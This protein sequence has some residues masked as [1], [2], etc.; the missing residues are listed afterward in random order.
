MRRPFRRPGKR[1]PRWVSLAVALVLATTGLTGLTGVPGSSGAAATAGAPAQPARAAAPAPGAQPARAAAHTVGF[2]HYSLTIDGHRLYLWSAEF[3]YWRLPSP[4]LWR[5][6]LEKLKAAGYN[7]T[8][9]YFDWGYH[10][11]A[12]GVYDFTGV[13][14]ID[15]L[16]DI[17]EEV[18]IY[19]IARPGPYINAETD[20]GGFPGWLVTQRGRARSS[21]PDFTAA[22]RDWLRRVDRIIARHQI[23]DGGGPVILYQIEN[24]YGNNTDAQYMQDQQAQVRADGITVPLTHNHCCGPSTWAT[25]PGSVDI[26]G[27]DSYPQGF[28]CSTPDRWNGVSTLP[29]FRDDAPIFTPEFQGGSFDPWGGPGYD[30]CRTLTGPDFE[31]VFYKNNIAAGATLQNFYMTYGGTSW[32]WLADPAQVYTSYDYGAAIKED[33]ELTAKYDETKRLGY[34]TQSF[35]PLTKT[36][37]IASQAPTSPAVRVDGRA[38]PD[39]NTHLYVVRHRDSTAT[40]TDRTHI[41]VDLSAK[42]VYTHDDPDGAL[43]YAGAGWSHVANESF[44]SGDYKNTESFSDQAGDSVTVTFTGTAVR[45]I[46]SYDA[47]HGIA[48]VFLDGTKVAT[49][50]GYGA[51][52][53]FQQV[54]YAASGLADGPHTLR[55]VAT[56]TANPAASGTFVV[57][58]AIDVPA[59]AGSGA[60]DVYP[61]VPQQPGTD[62]TLA[63]RDSKLIIAGYDMDSQRLQYSTS[64]LMTHGHIAGRDVALL[65]GRSGQDG[66][67]VLR[68]AAE[69][70][71]TVLSGSVQHTWDAARRDLRLNY[72]HGGLARVLVTPTGGAAGDDAAPLLL[73]IGTD[74]VAAQF[75]RQD[76]AAGP[77]LVRGPKLV[78]SASHAAGV[79][80]LRGDTTA[81]TDIEVYAAQTVRTITWN[82]ARVP[83]PRRG[84]DG[85]LTGRLAGPRP[86]TPPALTDWRFRQESP[87]ARPEFDDGRWRLA[88]KATTNNPTQPSAP[89]VLYADEYGFHHGD[90][91][92]RGHFTAHGEETGVS[93]SA[94]TGRA[95]TYSAWLNGTFL[96]STGDRAHRFDFP[97]GS[98]RPGRDN[99]LSVLVENMGHNEDFNADDSHKEPRGLTGATILGSTAQLGWRI[100]GSLGGE[101]L[102]DPARG[103]MNV[104]GLFG[105]RGGWHLPGFPDAA[106]SRVTLPRSDTRPGVAWYR[107]TF[108]LDLP[109]DQDVPMGV[110]IT[111]DPARRYRALLFVNGWQLGRYINHVGPQRTFPVPPGILRT[112]GANTLAIAVWNEDGDTGGLGAVTLDQYANL[113]T[114]LRVSNVP[115][116]PYDPRVYRT[117]ASTAALSVTG[118]DIIERGGTGTVTATFADPAG[119]PAARDVTVRLRAPDGWTVTPAGAVRLGTVRPGASTS[120]AW[121]VTGPAGDQPGAAVFSSTASYSQGG[122]GDAADGAAVVRVPPPPPTGSVFV[123]DIPFTSTNGWGPVERD[124]SNGE[125]AAGDGRTI[126]LNGTTYAKG[127]GVHAVGDVSVFLGGNCGRFTAVA[128]VDDEVGSSGSVTFSVVGDGATL[129]TTPTLTGSSTSAEIDVDVS[130]VQQ[131]DLVIGDGGNGNGTDHGDWA[132][133]RLSCAAP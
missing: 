132:D 74:E 88:D 112:N 111:D 1:L 110:R 79:L 73:L 43:A 15:R 87:E 38:N 44:T 99:V 62:I 18:G 24:E 126:T 76:T 101:D 115:S 3:H 20:S 120:A 65:Y 23:T 54:F 4:D 95:G 56:G 85:A 64:E 129:A 11:P 70:S 109:R 46:S 6:V 68:Y 98:L 71:V 61:S 108:D 128:G 91:W 8:S 26:P 97:A 84:D 36:D 72:T 28:N 48:D 67:T 78:R 42:P 45:W 63:G 113:A 27:R 107:T 122:R 47:N 104:G 21:A 94:I 92:Y 55:I 53:Q 131:L 117:P 60:E 25:G 133:A 96:G 77:V 93:L 103:P 19:V 35:G 102:V 39:D 2:D 29:R 127:L 5:D 14:D 121:K 59:G 86:V 82:G 17:A 40:T 31:K 90:V 16:L 50:D 123:S 58:D 49:V 13:R 116:P 81:A 75:W 83:T 100:Q 66:E 114:G 37:P 33:R 41:A 7:A 9:I 30:N 106:W 10:S 69:P 52:K 118:P 130:G 51:S 12:P 57:V 105:E 32:G 124:T 125:N 22:Y 119:R 89:P 80:A 34:L